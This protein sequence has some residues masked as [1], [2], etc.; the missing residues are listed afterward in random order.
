MDAFSFSL[1]LSLSLCLRL[2]FIRLT[3]SV[4][5]AALF[6]AEH[7][8]FLHKGISQELLGRRGD[9]RRCYEKALELRPKF[10][11]AFD[12]L[13]ILT[14]DE[15]KVRD[16]LLHSQSHPRTGIAFSHL[17]HSMARSFHTSLSLSLTIIHSLFSLYGYSRLLTLLHLFRAVLP[18]LLISVTALLQQVDESR[19]WYAK[20]LE[21]R[22]SDAVRIKMAL[23]LPPVYSSTKVR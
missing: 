10:Y 7:A 16:A 9:A 15:G 5:L 8:T 1:L 21:V 14:H 2:D 6:S 4:R 22:D 18:T 17:L 20:A 3:A 12:S 23:M 11:E 13:A 19:S